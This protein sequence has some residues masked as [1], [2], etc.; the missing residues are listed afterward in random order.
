MCNEIIILY[1]I[2]ETNTNICDHFNSFISNKLVADNVLQIEHGQY[3]SDENLNQSYNYILKFKTKSD[4]SKFTSQVSKE[5]KKLLKTIAPS[6]IKAPIDF[7][8]KTILDKVNDSISLIKPINHIVILPFK[9]NTNDEVI[10][11]CFS[12]LRSLFNELEGIRSFR[13]GKCKD[14]EKIYIFEMQFANIL[15]RNYY[16]KHPKHIEVAKFIIPL[17][18][19]GKNSIIAFDYLSPKINEPKLKFSSSQIFSFKKVAKPE[20]LSIAPT[21]ELSNFKI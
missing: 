13:Y 1:A 8:L 6:M 9:L 4:Y 5:Y 14:H 19:S 3:E 11:E 12:K 21:G 10:N 2:K 20:G 16:L 7:Q 17:L 15:T 18:E